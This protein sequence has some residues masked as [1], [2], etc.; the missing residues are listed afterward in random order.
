MSHGGHTGRAFLDHTGAGERGY[1]LMSMSGAAT[2]TAALARAPRGSTA[3]ESLA[4]DM[5]VSRRTL[6]RWRGARFHDVTV[7]GWVA[8]FVTRPHHVPVP[9]QVTP[10]REVDRDA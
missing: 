6:Y 1:R 5:G 9:V 3:I 7:G 2:I 8:T 10:W 4:R